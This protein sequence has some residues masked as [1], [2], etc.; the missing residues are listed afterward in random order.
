MKRFWREVGVV[1]AEG[2][3]RVV[4]DGRPVGTP[5][6]R[7]LVLPTETLARAIACEWRAVEGEVRPETLRLTR[8][9]NAATDQMPERRGAALELLLGYASTDLLC[10]RASE[11]PDLVRRQEV[12]WQPLLDWL[13][14]ARGVRLLVVHGI[15]PEPQP[16]AATRALARQLEALPDWPLVGLHALATAQGSL[17]LSLALMDARIEPGEAVATALLDE[18]YTTLRWGTEPEQEWRH[19]VLRLEVEAAT[20]FLRLLA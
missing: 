11:P 6:K 3:W 15:L 16:D 7:P 20:R 9:A 13:E 19:A 5:A 2:G 1:A 14:S 17:V 10:Y 12:A 18:L 4:L 8:L